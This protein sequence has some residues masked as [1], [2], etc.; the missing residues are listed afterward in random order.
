MGASVLGTLPTGGAWAHEQ[1]HLHI[2]VKEM[3][4]ILYGLRS[5][6]EIL[7]GQHVRVL[8]DNTTAVHVVNK[9]GTTRSP[10]C[11]AMAKEI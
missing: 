6:V 5:F 3:L 2:N 1:L 10:S 4:G 9:M 7:K 8:C 11:N